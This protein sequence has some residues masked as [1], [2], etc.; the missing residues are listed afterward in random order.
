MKWRLNSLKSRLML[1]LLGSIVLL[2]VLSFAA[3]GRMRGY[4]ARWLA[5][6][7]TGHDVLWLRTRLADTAPAERAGLLPLLRRAGYQALLQPADQAPAVPEPIPTEFEALR[8]TVQEQ[9][10]DAVAVQAI[11]ADGRY[12]LR[13][14]L[15]T[16]QALV[17][18]FD[19]EP[20]SS[21]PSAHQVLLYI[22]FVTAVVAAVSAW[23]VNVVTRPLVRLTVAG[24]ALAADIARA[25]PMDEGGPQEVCDLVAGFNAMQRAVQQQLRERIHILAAVSHDLKT[26]LTRL[27]LRANALPEGPLRERIEADLDAMDALV[28]EGLEYARSAQLREPRIP[29]N[30]TGLLE[31]MVE[32]AADL[33][34]DCRFTPT[35]GA[36]TVNAAP[37]ALTRL[38]Q[39]L[40]DN[41]L[42]YGGSA[43]V[44]AQRHEGGVLVQVADRGPGVAD[45]DLERM[46]EPFVRGE[47][48]RG[49]DAGG[50]GLGLAIARNIAIAHQ[51]RVWLAAREGGGLAAC[52]WLPGGDAA[53]PSRA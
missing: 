45:A 52:V 32:Q 39:N 37:R 38:V 27:K 48:S 4:E 40:I 8:H 53:A 1:I 41:A 2:Q 18:A 17:I 15:D 16:T 35:E 29:L 25:E 5:N 21:R 46:F 47:A 26:P 11:Q 42:R 9:A 33:G 30:L 19:E 36:L 13:L 51:G 34:A 23:A 6:E 10:G 7:Q 20:T 49:R 50:T 22:A 31:S 43:E 28:N 12:A 3:V 24:R 14:P 44:S